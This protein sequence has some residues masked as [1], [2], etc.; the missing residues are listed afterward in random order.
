MRSIECDLTA[1][2]WFIFRSEGPEIEENNNDP[3]YNNTLKSEYNFSNTENKVNIINH[4][5][6]LLN[7][8]ECCKLCTHIPL[9]VKK[10]YTLS[11]MLF[12]KKDYKTRC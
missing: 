2:N 10:T 4:T 8:N 9:Y 5:K 1:I 6:I 12:F 3:I 7:V 11:F